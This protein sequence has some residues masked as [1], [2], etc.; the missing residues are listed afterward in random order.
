MSESPATATTTTTTPH[1]SPFIARL[2][3]SLTRALWECSDLRRGLFT[4]TGFSLLCE[5]VLIA[6]LTKDHSRD[7][8]LSTIP[9]YVQKLQQALGTLINLHHG[10]EEGGEGVTGEDWEIASSALTPP[11]PEQVLV[12]PVWSGELLE[13]LRLCLSPLSEAQ[14]MLEVNYSRWNEAGKQ[15][16]VTSAA[17]SLRTAHARISKIYSDAVFPEGE[18]IT[19]DHHTELPQS[20]PPSAP[21]KE[22]SSGKVE[23]RLVGRLV[24]AGDLEVNGE[25]ISGCAL[26]IDRAT[27][28]AAKELP[29]YRECVIITLAELVE[30]EAASTHDRS[31]PGWRPIEELGDYSVEASGSAQW[32][33]NPGWETMRLFKF[34]LANGEVETYYADIDDGGNLCDDDGEPIGLSW[35]DATCYMDIPDA[36]TEPKDRLDQLTA[37]K[38][39]IPKNQG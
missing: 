7:L 30:L 37:V 17:Q 21:Q 13:T 25:E 23:P 31:T 9:P 35:Y 5:E 15:H 14:R 27:L 22:P 32:R 33:L 8:V 18:I 1:P 36:P 11:L 29:M 38:S 2:A 19:M 3:R 10:Q 28:I 39:P 4:P 34:H 6:T 16:A 24:F 12:A 20:S 26:D